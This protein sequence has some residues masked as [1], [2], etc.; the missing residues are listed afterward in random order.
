MSQIPAPPTFVSGLQNVLKPKEVVEQLNQ[1]IVGQPDAKRAVA[2]ALRNRWRRQ[3]LGED[4]RNEVSFTKSFIVAPLY[5]SLLM[6]L[7]VKQIIPKNILMI[8]PTGCGKVYFHVFILVWPFSDI[9]I[10][11]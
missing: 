6:N 7:D 1:Y 8:G 5:N 3:Q 10:V 4:M 11:T 9:Y 2:I